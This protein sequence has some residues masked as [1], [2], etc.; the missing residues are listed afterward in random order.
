M[1]LHPCNTMSQRAQH[2]TYS[3]GMSETTSIGQRIKARR[4]LRNLSVRTLADLAGVHASTLSRIENDKTAATNRITV[5]RIAQ[6]LQCSIQDLTGM[7]GVPADPESADLAASIYAATTALIET[8]LDEGPATKNPRPLA[9][10]ADEVLR[11]RELRQATNNAAAARLIPD[12]LR[13]AHAHVHGPESQQALRILALAAADTA[14]V[15]R[16]LGFLSEA[17]LAADRCRD[18]ARE[19][20]DPVILGLAAWERGHVASTCGALQRAR[21]I[22]ERGLDAVRDAQGEGAREIRGQLH[23]FA[24]WIEYMLGNAEETATWMAAAEEIAHETGQS[25]AL[26]MAWGPGN[27]SCWQ[28]SMATEAGEAGKA[29]EIGR[30]FDPT[31]LPKTRVTAAR[32]DLARAL[33]SEG[34]DEQALRMMLAAER[35]GPQLVH[36]SPLARETVRALLERSKRDQSG[37]TGLAERMAVAH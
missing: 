29:I 25:N 12:L 33:A 32:V 5:S 17:W 23:A 2:P 8:D 6:A 36:R 27:L 22:T 3:V 13:E 21:G 28:I 26:G 24:G 10:L 31:D 37:I 16:Y 9:Q 30:T 35:T 15:V 18:V 4:N 20:S 11:L 1:V 7:P 14:S 19:L 34:Q